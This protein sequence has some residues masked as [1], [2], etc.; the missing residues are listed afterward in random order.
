MDF[1]ALC[2]AVGRLTFSENLD[3][4]PM[5]KGNFAAHLREK[6]DFARHRPFVNGEFMAPAP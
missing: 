1:T 6:R 5:G 3:I 4:A 2:T